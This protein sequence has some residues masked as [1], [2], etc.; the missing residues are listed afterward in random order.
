MLPWWSDV[1]IVQSDITIIVPW[2]PSTGSKHDYLFCYCPLAGI[3]FEVLRIE[4]YLYL[5]LSMRCRLTAAKLTYMG[6][7]TRWHDIL[8][9]TMGLSLKPG[10]Y[11]QDGRTDKL[12]YWKLATGSIHDYNFCYYLLVFY[13]KHW[14]LFWLSLFKRVFPDS[15]LTGLKI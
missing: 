13:S 10:L 7:F 1:T 11:T 3:L 5:Y 12:H 14:E 4:C 15:L 8:Y 2:Q 9:Q 6:V